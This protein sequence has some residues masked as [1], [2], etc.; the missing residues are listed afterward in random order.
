MPA[1]SHLLRDSLAYPSSL[2]LS[3]SITTGDSLDTNTA[4]IRVLPELAVVP[5]VID[6]SPSVLAAEAGDTTA[7]D[8]LETDVDFGWSVGIDDADL[9]KGT[10]SGADAG[11]GW[12]DGGC[13]GHWYS[14][15]GGGG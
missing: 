13:G 2:S 8:G 12:G 6:A 10:E 3:H 7:H 1:S 15:G 14:E 11:G 5:R 4:A 9:V